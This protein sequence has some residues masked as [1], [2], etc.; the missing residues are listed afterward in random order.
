M[1]FSSGPSRGSI[2]GCAGEWFVGIRT[3]RAEG[4]SDFWESIMVR[5]VLFLAPW[6]WEGVRFVSTQDTGTK[7]HTL[8]V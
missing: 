6:G 5:F 2:A 1:G 3:A 7:E 8:R 4:D